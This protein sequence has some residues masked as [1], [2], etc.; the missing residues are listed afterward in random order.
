[1]IVDLDEKA[2]RRIRRIAE[3]DG[4]RAAL[5]AMMRAAGRG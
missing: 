4:I 5:A 2:A 3:R 1:M